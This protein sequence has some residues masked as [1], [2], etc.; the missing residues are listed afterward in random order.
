MSMNIS[1]C[2][3]KQESLHARSAL[4]FSRFA[5]SNSFESLSIWSQNN[6][7]GAKWGVI[8]N[9]ISN[10]TVVNIH[11]ILYRWCMQYMP[12]GK[13]QITFEIVDVHFLKV[14]WGRTCVDV[15]TC[16]VRP[17][18]DCVFIELL[19]WQIIPVFQ[20]ENGLLQLVVFLY[21]SHYNGYNPTINRKTNTFFTY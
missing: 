7:F 11:Q 15:F 21:R 8:V 6:V 16:W 14:P 2:T 3:V 5:C 1:L 19:R 17:Y 9:S 10:T 12:R 13:I 4:R 20:M 18:S